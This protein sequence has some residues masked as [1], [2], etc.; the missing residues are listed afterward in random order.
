[1]HSAIRPLKQSKMTGMTP[2]TRFM[3]SGA[4]LLV[5]LNFFC[6]RTYAQSTNAANSDEFQ[7]GKLFAKV[8]I[9]TNRIEQG[10]TQTDANPGIQATLGYKWEQFQAGLW[11]SNVR[12]VGEN[13]SANLRLF[14]AYKFIFTRNADLT[15]RYDFNRYY[16]GGSRNGAITGLNLNIY[17]YHILYDRNDNWEGLGES[18]RYGF[19]KEFEL[20]TSGFLLDIAAGY[21]I[22]YVDD[23]T[24]YFDVHAALGYRLA[25]IKYELCGSFNSGANQFGNRG[26]PFAYLNFS[27]AF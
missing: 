15:V 5:V 3:L 16:N 1:M 22:L 7:P 20:G 13:E 4:V 19:Q 24:N 18:I 25:D 14:G 8:A 6:G 9:G 10:L 12:Y 2:K 21:N 17:Q 27:A 23:Y 26:G 11:G